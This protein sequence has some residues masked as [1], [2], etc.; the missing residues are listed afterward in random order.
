MQQI[1]SVHVFNFFTKR[2]KTLLFISARSFVLIAFY[3]F[4]D[5]NPFLDYEKII[6]LRESFY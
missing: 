4:Y 6:S 5:Y 3:M 2:N 1:H